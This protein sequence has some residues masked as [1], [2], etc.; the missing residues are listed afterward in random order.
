MPADAIA[1]ASDHTTA[2]AGVGFHPVAVVAG[3][4]S[5]DALITAALQAA[6]V[7]AAIADFDVSIITGFALIDSAITA[8][9]DAALRCAAVAIDL[10]AVV[11]WLN[12][13]VDDAIAACR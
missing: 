1:A 8:G 10:V 7:V 5:V 6:L 12:A 11:A 13:I 4:T 9:L 2:R 3:F